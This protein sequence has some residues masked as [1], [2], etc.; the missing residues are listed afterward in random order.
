MKLNGLKNEWL[1]L[2]IVAAPFCVAGLLW[3]KIPDWVPTHWNA[4]GQVDGYSTKVFGT[5]L[6]PMINVCVALFLLLLPRIDPKLT[7]YDAEM[8]TGIWRTVK[9]IR[10]A[11]TGFM[12]L[13]AFAMMAAAIGA[14]KDGAQFNLVIYAGISLLFIVMGNFMSKLRPNYFVGVRTPWT[15]ESK[16]VWAKTHRLAGRLMV[17]GGFLMLVLCLVIPSEQFAFFVMLPITVIMS[18][19]SILYSY[20]T[21]RKEGR[22]T[23]AAH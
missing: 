22:G 5:F 10:L 8:R 6:L 14:F 16:E 11:I 23:A 2:L 3:D 15:L 18:F 13:V 19:V 4:R 21:F 12:S 9:I 1:Q 7:K 17:L 20:L